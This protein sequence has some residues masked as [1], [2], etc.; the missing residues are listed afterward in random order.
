MALFIIRGKANIRMLLLIIIHCR[1]S[2]SNCAFMCAYLHIV[3]E[4]VASLAFQMPKLVN[5]VCCG[6]VK[7]KIAYTKC[8]FGVLGSNAN[9]YKK[10][11]LSCNVFL[12]DFNSQ[13]SGTIQ[14][15]NLLSICSNIDYVMMYIVLM[16]C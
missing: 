11:T 5:L 14:F 12:S 10:H 16:V 7:I 9:N 6:L 13:P 1:N 2:Q 3:V 8:H 4:S 15:Y